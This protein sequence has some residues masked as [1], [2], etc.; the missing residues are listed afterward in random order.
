MSSGGPAG[1]AIELAQRITRW[2][3]LGIALRRWPY[4]WAERQWGFAPAWWLRVMSV[5]MVTWQVLRSRAAFPIEQ[6]LRFDDEGAEVRSGLGQRRMEWRQ[7][8]G[9]IEL[10]PCWMLTAPGVDL[11]V[12]HRQLPRAESQRL[13]QL[14]DKRLARVEPPKP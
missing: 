13:R 11:P 1:G 8:S 5:P 10:G 2:D 3:S 12:M 14:L 7:F 6:Q 4:S 9:W